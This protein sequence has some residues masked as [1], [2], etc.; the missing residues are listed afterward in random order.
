MFE[1]VVWS[2][3]PHIIGCTELF[4]IT[5]TLELFPVGKGEFGV[6]PMSLNYVRVYK[7]TDSVVNGYWKKKKNS[8]HVPVVL[9]TFYAL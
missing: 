3:R 5:E 4:D 8:V 6:I 7:I 2:S 9:D 1:T